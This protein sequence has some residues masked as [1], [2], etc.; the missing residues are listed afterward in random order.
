M[1]A[2]QLSSSCAQD[3]STRRYATAS[4]SRA[5]PSRFHRLMPFPSSRLMARPFASMSSARTRRIPFRPSG[6]P[7]PPSRSPWRACSSASPPRTLYRMCASSTWQTIRSAPSR[8]ALY[9][10]EQTQPIRHHCRASASAS[11][12]PATSSPRLRQSS[13]RSASHLRRA[14]F[15]IGSVDPYAPPMPFA[16]AR[17]YARVAGVMAKSITPRPPPRRASASSRP[18]RAL[19][20]ALLVVSWRSS[21]AQRDS[22]A[23][24]F[25]RSCS[26]MT[27]EALSRSAIGVL[28]PL[29]AAHAAS[30]GLCRSSG[31]CST[32]S[33]FSELSRSSTHTP[34]R[35]APRVNSRSA[36]TA[37]C[38]ARLAPAPARL[39]TATAPPTTTAEAAA[40]RRAT[41]PGPRRKS[42]SSTRNPSSA[43]CSALAKSLWPCG[44]AVRNSFIATVPPR[45][46]AVR[47][48]GCSRAADPGHARARGASLR[49]RGGSRA[50]ARGEKGEDGGGKGCGGAA[51]VA[52]GRGA[53]PK[54]S[55]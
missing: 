31:V 49:R 53:A 17:M 41:T 29:R 24:S 52:G 46:S 7:V 18:R 2:S 20:D 55:R 42:G 44:P 35:A 45:P 40:T 13:R 9:L 6:P 27:F 47:R 38:A 23:K 30:D 21:R 28:S 43:G 33:A 51:G 5:R 15:Q 1:S 14:C 19:R 37:H 22:P 3:A 8:K 11:P 39:W 54:V 10:R 36:R 4:L 26:M 32:C 48:C 16:F 34:M 50:P 25:G 12:A